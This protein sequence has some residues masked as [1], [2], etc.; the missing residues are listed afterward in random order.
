MKIIVIL[1]PTGV[2]KTKLSIELAKKM[3]AEIINADATQV[4]IEP[5]IGTAKITED[6]ME[7]IP[8]HML[9]L[10]SIKEN[11]TVKDYQEQGRI[12]LNRLIKENKNVIIVGGSGLYLKAL[13]YDY[14]FKEEENKKTYEKLTNEELK[15]KVD[16]IYKEN[17]I[18]VNNRKRLERFLSHYEETGEIIKNKEEKDTPLYD[19]TLI[20]LTKDKETLYKRLNVRVDEMLCDGLLEECR[21]LNNMD[22]PKLMT[23]IGYRE[24]LN[25]INHKIPINIAINEAKRRTRNYAKRQITFM[26]H[27]FK[28]VNW[29]EVDFENFNNTIKKVEALIGF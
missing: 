4:Y 8:H 25:F 9:N 12:I 3:H 18:H 6:Q 27:Q 17:N 2:G 15:S 11:F 23:L 22:A 19:F 16:S 14:K 28:N 29:V 1:G 20:G 13:L 10:V 26:T 21:S 5:V 24:F 7:N